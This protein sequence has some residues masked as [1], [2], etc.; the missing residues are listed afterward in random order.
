MYPLTDWNHSAQNGCPKGV[1]PEICQSLLAALDHP[2]SA[3]FEQLQ[4]FFVFTRV[5]RCDL[6]LTEKGQHDS[7]NRGVE[8]TIPLFTLLHRRSKNEAVPL[9]LSPIKRE[10]VLKEVPDIISK[11]QTYPKRFSE[12]SS[13]GSRHHAKFHQLSA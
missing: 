3:S 8:K 2:F 6:F 13:F 10:L 9:N 7:S 11:L 1:P 12:V 5:V 4:D